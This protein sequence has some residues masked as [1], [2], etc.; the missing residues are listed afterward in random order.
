M[1]IEVTGFLSWNGC[2][3][4]QAQSA[5]FIGRENE[6]G[7]IRLVQGHIVKSGGSRLQDS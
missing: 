5:H 2:W 6:T 1:W 3:R 4:D 7:K